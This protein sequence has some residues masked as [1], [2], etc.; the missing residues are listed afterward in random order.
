MSSVKKVENELE[1]VVP[2][3]TQRTEADIMSSWNTSDE[4]MVSIHCLT[5][6]HAE[7]I[8]DAIHGFLIQK[9]N[10]PFEI[11]I[12][13][14]ASTDGTQRVIEKYAKEYPS[15][16]KPFYQK[17]NTFSKGHRTELYNFLR[18]KGKYTALCEGDD[19]W[20]DEDK[21]QIQVSYLEKNPSVVICGHDVT[22]VDANCK[23]I[24]HFELK[25]SK[26]RKHSQNNLIFGINIPSKSALWRSNLPVTGPKMPGGDTFLFS[27]F[28][29]FGKGYNF[30]K[31]M[32]V[33]RMHSGGVWAGIDREEQLKGVYEI[34][35]QLPDYTSPKFKS[36]S[37]LRFMLFLI[38]YRSDLN[39]PNSEIINTAKEVLGN[40]NVNSFIYISNITAKKS[41]KNVL[42]A[43]GVKR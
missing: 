30:K 41:I 18:V 15:L 1:Y 32:G 33:Y 12:H 8:E 7:F 19:F 36:I 43:L 16:I 11:L 24:N 14:D 23:I 28:G 4:I 26:N 34:Y 20:F 40:L 13:D 21:L 10:F 29:N 17:E 31:V 35:S 6:N 5:F 39:I 27:Y 37:Y 25:I 2:P 3:R 38:D 22:Q 9:T 42:K